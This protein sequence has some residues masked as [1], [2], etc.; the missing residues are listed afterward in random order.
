MKDEL[1]DELKDGLRLVG[2]LFSFCKQDLGTSPRALRL[3]SKKSTTAPN[4]PD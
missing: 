4:F 1:K 3:I 2:Q